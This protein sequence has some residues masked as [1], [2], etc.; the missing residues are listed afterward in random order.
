MKWSYNTQYL[1]A[2]KILPRNIEEYNRTVKVFNF[3]NMLDIAMEVLIANGITNVNI[4]TSDQTMFSSGLMMMDPKTHF[5]IFVYGI[6]SPFKSAPFSRRKEYSHAIA[7]VIDN[8]TRSCYMIN[9]LSSHLTKEK[10]HLQTMLS[11]LP[12]YQVKVLSASSSSD[13]DSNAAQNAIANIISFIN[14]DINLETGEGLFQA[15]QEYGEI[16]S[17]FAHALATI[18][19]KRENEENLLRTFHV[20]RALIIALGY[21]SNDSIR[22]EVLSLRLALDEDIRL[23]NREDDAWKQRMLPDFMRDFIEKNPENSVARIIGVNFYDELTADGDIKTIVMNYLT[24]KLAAFNEHSIAQPVPSSSMDPVAPPASSNTC[25]KPSFFKPEFPNYVNEAR[26]KYA[27]SQALIIASR[28]M[29]DVMKRNL[30]ALYDRL[31]KEV[32][33]DTEI[34]KEMSTDK[35]KPLGVVLSDFFQANPDNLSRSLFTHATFNLLQQELETIPSVVE[36]NKKFVS[37]FSNL[38]ELQ[39]EESRVPAQAL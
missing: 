22:E 23:I 5:Q 16:A 3:K 21:L 19:N 25:P 20:K 29:S 11:I 33:R 6:E 10:T 2:S 12:D 1:S 24:D 15:G 13:T 27:L 37:Y 7:V 31:E 34:V 4:L 30:Q 14:G 35:V 28:S 9:S 39:T 38:P 32:A 17:I 18:N 26:N 8:E 36:K